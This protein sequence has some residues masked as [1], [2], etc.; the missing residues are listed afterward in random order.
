MEGGLAY[1]R[2]SQAAGSDGLEMDARAAAMS[3]WDKSTDIAGWGSGGGDV[4]EKKR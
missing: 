3:G 4:M 1:C 2:R